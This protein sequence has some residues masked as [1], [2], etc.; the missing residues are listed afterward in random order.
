MFKGKF[1]AFLRKEYAD[2][3]LKFT[4]ELSHLAHRSGFKL[5]IKDLYDKDW[6]VYCKK[7][8]KN[9]GQIIE[10]LGRYSH[11]IAITNHRIQHADTNQVTFRVKDYKDRSKIKT[12]SFRPQEFIR[13]FLLHVLPEGLCKIRYYGLFAYRNRSTV[14]LNCK[15]AIGFSRHK[16]RFAGLNWVQMFVVLTGKNFSVCPV[17]NKGKMALDRELEAFRG[18][19]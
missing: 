6:V 16:S 11:R 3:N 12:L 8:F 1:M 14:L 17:C 9:T 18:P 13:R 19:P 10:Y 7:P 5:W 4:G 2:G 15:K